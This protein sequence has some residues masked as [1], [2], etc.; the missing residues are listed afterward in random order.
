MEISTQVQIAIIDLIEAIKN[1]NL[2]E[3]KSQIEFINNNFITM[4][5]TGILNEYIPFFELALSSGLNETIF[6][7]LENLN[8]LSGKDRILWNIEISTLLRKHDVKSIQNFINKELEN[9][10]ILAYKIPQLIQ[11][12]TIADDYTSL[13]L[14]RQKLK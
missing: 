12:S 2:E 7:T 10:S 11:L 9:E 1:N 13:K 3:A 8:N 5:P 14:L 6:Y 4:S